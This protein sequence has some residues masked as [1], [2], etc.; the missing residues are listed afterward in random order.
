MLIRDILLE[1]DRDRARQALGDTLWKA[2]LK[3]GKGL[4]RLPNS[5][6]D[7]YASEPY[8][9][10][11]RA[12]ADVYASPELQKRLADTAL[13]WIEGVDPSTNK[14]Y[15]QWMARMY[16]NGSEPRIEDVKSTL[17]DKVKKFNKLNIKR[18]LPAG[19]ND[20]NRYK[21]ATELYDEMDKYPDV[22]VLEK[23][24]SKKEYEDD[25]VMVVVPEDQKAA[26]Y[27]GSKTR[28]C[29]AVDGRDNYFAHYS[30]D[31]PLYI[32]IPKHPKSDGEKYQLHFD[33]YQYMDKNDDP[34][35][36]E[37]LLTKRFPGLLKHFMADPKIGEEL[38]SMVQ[39]TDD[40][41]L[42]SVSDQI[43]D[44]AGDRVND[45]LADWESN[46]HTYYDWLKENGYVLDDGEV[47]WAQAPSFTE[48]NDDAADWYNTM[49]DLLH[50]TPDGMR[51]MVA[52]IDQKSGASYDE[53][54]RGSV[55]NLE[56]YIADAIEKA[57]R[58]SGYGES[59]S[60]WI[61]KNIRIVRTKSGPKV[62]L[63]KRDA[64]GRP[65]A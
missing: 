32:L 36:L 27:W 16:A 65:I 20:I 59:M 40:K 64:R 14:K 58:R 61:H 54:F 26:C 33:S 28:W 43:W 21:T 63:I 35:E 50:P 42:Q 47:L 6:L 31:G 24:S 18:M 8:T 46:D 48:Y 2:A 56:S 1:Y 4:H 25:D 11:R 57:F 10:S 37:W 9:D 44:I 60:E 49:E 17:A 34:V 52:D 30:K 22:E 51:R 62:E 23:G 13:Q 12:I 41:T 45:I 55:Y 7:V 39:F 19:K 15:T 53:E 5:A 38:G 29:T 3:D